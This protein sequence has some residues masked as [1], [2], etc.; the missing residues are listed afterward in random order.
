MMTEFHL[1]TVHVISNT[2]PIF[3]FSVM[4]SKPETSITPLSLLIAA[5]THSVTS[6]ISDLCSLSFYNV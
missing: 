3:I 2:Y 4:Y 6:A 1:A 5:L